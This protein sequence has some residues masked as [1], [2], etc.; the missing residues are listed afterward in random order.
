MN[1]GKVWILGAG[2]GDFGLLTLKALRA[3]QEAQVIVYDR[4][5]SPRILQEAP[6]DAKMIN[7][8]KLS[9]HHEVPQEQINQILATEAR[10]G[11]RVA[12]I[13]GGDPFVFGR[14]G[15]EGEYLYDQG[16]PFEVI[17]G[18]SSSIA[19]P[20][21]A[22]IPVTHRD[23]CSSFHIVTGH[24]R[25]DREESRTDY[26]HYAK[27]EG[28]LV[29]L[30]GIKNLSEICAALIENGKDPDTPVAVIEN[31]TR[32][33]QRRVVG[34]LMN[35]VEKIKAAHI[36]PPAV[37]VIGK[38]VDL[39]QKL[40]WFGQ[41]PLLGKRILVTRARE[42]ASSLVEKLEA[43]GAEPIAFPAIRIEAPKEWTRLDAAILAAH[44]YT[45][46]VFTSVNGVQAFFERMKAIGRD[47]RS[48]GTAKICAIGDATAAALSERGI[49]TDL[50]PKEFMTTALLTELIPLLTPSDKVLLARAD[51][52]NPALAQALEEK[53]IP[54]DDV[55]A[56]HTVSAAVDAHE[57]QSLLAEDSVD[58]ITFASSSTV[59]NFVSMVG[60][61]ALEK[62]RK[63]KIVCIGPVTANTAQELGVTPHRVAR[64]FTIDGLIEC[65]LK[66]SETNGSGA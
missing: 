38:V 31:G 10:S 3:I 46:I 26:A 35:I 30:M 36:T 21:Y 11:R 54:Y 45:W 62:A 5:V 63:V 27:I 25:P 47:I 7:V 28:T 48:M 23:Y 16:I 60:T 4:L 17:P 9:D 13:K 58:Y 22:G 57:I 53:G 51:I 15:E 40:D 20:A 8:G 65:I 1:T 18:I 6:Q 59:K 32:Y 64:N 2:P 42:Q 34:N 41:K 66:E 24:E 49:L 33:N 56:Y 55:A 12:R 61:A 52:A 29:F 50:I 43:L 19:V 44:S 37:T 39:H 14:G